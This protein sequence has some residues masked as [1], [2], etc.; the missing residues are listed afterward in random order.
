MED[1]FSFAD[2]LGPV[3]IVHVQEQIRLSGANPKVQIEGIVMTMHD[4]RTNLSRQVVEE[5]S[6]VFPEIIYKAIIPRS[7]RL[8]EAPSFGKPILLYDYD[9]P[10]SQAYIQLASEIIDRENAGVRA[11]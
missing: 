7:I 1:M 10:G 8:G 3:K 11:A 9:C 4:S 5:V 6:K 2:D